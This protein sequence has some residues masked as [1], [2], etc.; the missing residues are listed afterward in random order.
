MVVAII[1][2]AHVNLRT[3]PP[4]TSI[5]LPPHVLSAAP[6]QP[7]SGAGAHSAPHASLARKPAQEVRTHQEG[8]GQPA[9][10]AH[11]PL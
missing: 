10:Q 4:S 9:Q 11:E 8:A 7:A 5:L 1:H 2:R 3:N 6:V